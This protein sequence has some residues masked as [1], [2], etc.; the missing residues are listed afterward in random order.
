MTPLFSA[1]PGMIGLSESGGETGKLI[2]WAEGLYTRPYKD[3]LL[4]DNQPPWEHAFVSIGNGL[5]VQAEPG[6]AQVA[7]ASDHP[8]I[9]W[10]TNIYKLAAPGQLSLIEA[11]AKGYVGTPY[12]FLD[13]AAL[14][15]HR[16]APG[17]DLGLQEFIA[18]NK[19]MICSQLADQCYAD[20]HVPIFTDGRWPGYVSP[21]DLYLRDLELGRS[22]KTFKSPGWRR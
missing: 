10:C 6:G 9:Y 2:H 5:I 1:P 22:S 19:H 14:T 7:H 17:L 18:S 12:S 4:P 20:A 3:W 13:Y 21:M 11:A 15:A 16:L 8:V